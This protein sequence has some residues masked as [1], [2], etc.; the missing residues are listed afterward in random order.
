[1][2]DQLARLAELHKSGEITDVEFKQA[3]EQLLC[4][5]LAENVLATPIVVEA[6]L[7]AV[8]P[9][10]KVPDVTIIENPL[11]CMAYAFML[12]FPFFCFGCCMYGASNIE[13][14][15]K[16]RIVTIT[17]WKG[18]FTSCKKVREVPFDDIQCFG[19]HNDGC[20]TSVNG[21]IMFDCVLL[22][23]DGTRINFEKMADF[24]T[25][26]KF[27]LECT[28]RVVDDP[29]SV[30]PKDL[31]IGGAMGLMC[32]YNT[33]NYNANGGMQRS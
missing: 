26:E 30:N 27:C 32:G 33:T 23:K 31:Y 5:P 18:V 3:K 12:P 6:Q 21:L 16:T 7:A 20:P 13:I 17:S 14:N 2:T 19:F 28:Q 11:P 24:W 25:A 9:V 29:S 1:M 22:L 4:P 15:R 8:E 10:I